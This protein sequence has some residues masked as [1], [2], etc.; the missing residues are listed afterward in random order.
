M[1][2]Y[3]KDKAATWA[4]YIEP[5]DIVFGVSISDPDNREVFYGRDLLHLI[6][7]SGIGS[8][9]AIAEIEIDWDTDDPE[10]LA[11]VCLTVKGQEVDSGRDGR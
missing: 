5:A 11:A 8:K 10:I 4:E 3:D 2:D 1:T 7:D 6:A 9:V